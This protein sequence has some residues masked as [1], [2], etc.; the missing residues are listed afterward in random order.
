MRR[1]HAYGLDIST[2][3]ITLHRR[4]GSGCLAALTAR[5][6]RVEPP[7]TRRRA[8]AGCARL[9]ML[10]PWHGGGKPML[11]GFRLAAVGPE[12]AAPAVPY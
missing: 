12:Q 4:A 1:E 8:H 5:Y 10:T 9:K 6:G 11:A 3:Q 7:P 2:S